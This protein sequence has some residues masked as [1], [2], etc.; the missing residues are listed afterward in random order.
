M[1][2]KQKNKIAITFFLISIFTAFI[3]PTSAAEI[4]KPFEMNK[5]SYV[6]IGEESELYP[7]AQMSLYQPQRNKEEL[8]KK[9]EEAI[10]KAKEEKAIAEQKEIEEKNRLEQETKELEA[11][12]NAENYENAGVCQI[13]SNSVKNWMPYTALAQNSTQ[14]QII[15][16]QTTITEDGFLV[17]EDG[18]VGV[19]LGSYYGELGSKFKVTTDTG[20]VFKVIKVDAKSDN[21]VI[22]GCYHAN[23][24]SILEFVIDREK[25]TAYHNE[26][27]ISGDFNVMPEYSGNI[28]KIERLM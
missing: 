10:E 15:N 16:T 21:D 13:N 28:I 14:M 2:I 26:V 18:F 8:D 22:D 4:D 7:F 17:T 1:Q 11:I 5:P 3:S 9:L 6:F 25:M 23:N 24:N 27:I 12:K 19:A 20:N